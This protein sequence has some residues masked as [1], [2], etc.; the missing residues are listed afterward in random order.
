MGIIPYLNM[1]LFNRMDYIIYLF[2]NFRR[3]LQPLLPE[4]SSGVTWFITKGYISSVE[5]RL[6]K[7][8]SCGS[9]YFVSDCLF[10][11]LGGTQWFLPCSRVF[12]GSLASFMIS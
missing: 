8:E 11:W 10:L 12:Q 9:P 7:L 1:D 5:P 3:R 4:F 2:F 6:I